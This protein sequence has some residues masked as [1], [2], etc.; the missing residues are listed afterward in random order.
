[1]SAVRVDGLQLPI[2]RSRRVALDERRHR[3]DSIGKLNCIEV[4]RTESAD[5]RGV[6]VSNSPTVTSRALATPE[7]YVSAGVR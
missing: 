1:L 7:T 4:E 2:D 6:I 5:C 3:D